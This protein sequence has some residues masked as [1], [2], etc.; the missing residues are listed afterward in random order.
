MGRA[1]HPRRLR[2]SVLVSVVSLVALVSGAASTASDAATTGFTMGI[3]RPALIR[4]AIISVRVSC[5]ASQSRC[6]GATAAYTVADPTQSVPALRS[7]LLIAPSQPFSLRHGQ[8][9][10]LRLLIPLSVV[11]ALRQTRKLSVTTYTLAGNP[12][13]N[14]TAQ[15]FSSATIT[16]AKKDR[17]LYGLNRLRLR[18]R[19]LRLNNNKLSLTV[20]CTGASAQAKASKFGGCEGVIEVFG[21]TLGASPLRLVS[22]GAGGYFLF[23]NSTTNVSIRLL[24]GRLAQLKSQPNASLVAYSIASDRVDQ[25]GASQLVNLR[26]S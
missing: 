25:L 13:T 5:P 18:L 11:S 14:A 17:R 4:N 7:G 1:A 15:L 26:I 19:K 2:A 20:I 23:R 10:T 9:R 16:L 21:G 22:L 6:N 24:K 3:S 12:R 8:S